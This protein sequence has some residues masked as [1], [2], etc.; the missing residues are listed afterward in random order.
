MSD[1]DEDQNFKVARAAVYLFRLLNNGQNPSATQLIGL[2]QSGSLAKRKGMRKTDAC[3]LLRRFYEKEKSKTI[4][5]PKEKET[6]NLLGTSPEPGDN[7]PELSVHTTEPI[8][9][10]M[11][12]DE[13]SLGTNE[14]NPGTFPEH[15]GRVSNNQTSNRLPSVT[16]PAA[17]PKQESLLGDEGLP[18][19]TTAVKGRK[20]KP[21][22]KSSPGPRPEHF[23]LDAVGSLIQPHLA[24]MTIG[25]WRRNNANAARDMV[26]SGVTSDSAAEIWLSEFERTGVPIIMLKWLQE[27]IANAAARGVKHSHMP[28]NDNLPTIEDDI[29][30]LRAVGTDAANARADEMEAKLAE[31]DRQIL[32]ERAASGFVPHLEVQ[33]A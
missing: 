3:A 19:K 13:E 23:I 32:L 26:E 27:R 25:I 4:P 33:H 15:H 8:L 2:M 31:S 20:Q 29:A 12:T 16:T 30:A 21:A 17:P 5:G 22:V 18:K 1:S 9:S 28:S 11:G 10:T 14:K 6:R 7:F 24:G